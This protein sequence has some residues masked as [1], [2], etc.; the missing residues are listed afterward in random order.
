MSSISGAS[1]TFVGFIA[2][3][4]WSLLAVLTA[5]TGEVPPFQL[6]AMSLLVGGIVGVV[7][8][9][10][11]GHKSSVSILPWQVWLLGVGGIFGYH[12][13]FFT[14]LRNAPVVE[15]GLINYLWPVLI[16]LFSSFLP[17]ERLKV[18]HVIGGFLGFAGAWLIVSKGGAVA[19]QAEY[20]FG[21]G[22]A[23]LAALAWSSY[24]VLSRRYSS[25]P[26]DVI[27]WFCFA[28]ALFSLMCHLALEKTVW[29]QGLPEWLCV[30]GLGLGPVGAAFYVWDYGVKHGDIQVLGASSY[31]APL[32]STII[33]VMVGYAEPTWVIVLAGLLISGGAAFASKDV[34]LRKR[35][36]LR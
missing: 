16:I 14:A 8:R 19:F 31:L 10:V 7:Y 1:A 35:Q 22:I 21:Y 25:V 6:T 12:F 30:A 23:V 27:T 11:S 20:A 28:G 15:A 4:M 13:L 32:L 17:G 9:E 26:S 18:H 33:L 3:L 2:V 34:F 29:P 5:G 36:T 24:S